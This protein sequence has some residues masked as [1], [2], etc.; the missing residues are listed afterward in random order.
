MLA[1]ILHDFLVEHGAL[2]AFLE[3]KNP[4]WFKKREFRNYIDNCVDYSMS[5]HLLFKHNAKILRWSVLN[6]SF[7]KHTEKLKCSG[8]IPEW[9]T[10]EEVKEAMRFIQN[11]RASLLRKLNGKGGTNDQ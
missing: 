9:N 7:Y 11:P 10:H 4:G 2:E 6:D 1:K 8:I 5:D 3:V